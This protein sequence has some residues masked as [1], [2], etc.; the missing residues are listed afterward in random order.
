MP[1]FA[2]RAAR[3]GKTVGRI[4]DKSTRDKDARRISIPLFFSPLFWS[5][6]GG[7]GDVATTREM[8][9]GPHFGI[10][11]PGAG[12]Q[13]AGDKASPLTERTRRRRAG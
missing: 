5:V 10:T 11:I 13:I 2:S 7:G 3:G 4:E 1:H 8:L 6:V 12:R 9:T